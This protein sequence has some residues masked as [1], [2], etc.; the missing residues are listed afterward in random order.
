MRKAGRRVDEDRILK[1]II[2]LINAIFSSSVVN[3]LPSRSLSQIP[4]NKQ[5][6]KRLLHALSQI[7]PSLSDKTLPPRHFSSWHT[8]S[9]RSNYTSF[10]RPLAGSTFSLWTTLLPRHLSVRGVLPS[11]HIEHSIGKLYLTNLGGKRQQGKEIKNMRRKTQQC[12]S[13]ISSS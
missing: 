10:T 1:L 13:W 2:T 8:L 5:T 3:I 9:S 6:L 11:S 7:T 4:R 12:H